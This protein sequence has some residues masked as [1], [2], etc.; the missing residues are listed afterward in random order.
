MILQDLPLLLA[1]MPIMS[2]VI[3]DRCAIVVLEMTTIFVLRK[4]YS[5]D[6]IECEL[7]VIG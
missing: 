5:I 7:A 3:P 1:L 6:K 4:F 2:T